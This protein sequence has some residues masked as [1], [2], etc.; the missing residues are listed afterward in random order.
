MFHKQAFHLLA[1]YQL[2]TGPSNTK[3]MIR[4]E[5][6]T[7]AKPCPPSSVVQA[8]LQS[9]EN[10]LQHCAGLTSETHFED[11]RDGSSEPHCPRLT[12]PDTPRHHCNG[13]GQQMG[14]D[15]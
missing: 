4:S 15:D 12:Q 10:L 3:T 6:S 5:R 9:L 13:Q 11:R 2:P 7:K 14:P 8:P 1:Q